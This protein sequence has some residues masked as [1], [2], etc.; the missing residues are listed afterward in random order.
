MI[1][2][3]VIAGPTAS[4]KTDLA[5]RIA[6]ETGA[7]VVNVD[8]VQVY[9]GFDVGTAKPDLP[10]RRGI[11]HHLIDV[12]DPPETI[13]AMEFAKRA[14]HVI[15]KLHQQ[16]T[17]II[18]TAGTGLWL[19]ALLRGL[20]PVPPADGV[21][22]DRLQAALDSDGAAALHERLARVDAESAKNIHPNDTTRVIRCLEVHEQ[23]GTPMSTLRRNHNLGAPRYSAR[24]VVLDEPMPTLTHRIESRLDAMLNSGWVEEVES[25]LDRW[26]SKARG[27]RSVGYKELV[28]HLVDGLAMDATRQAIRK[29][30]RIY[31][32]RQATWFRSEP[33]VTDRLTRDAFLTQASAFAE[34][35]SH[36]PQSRGSGAM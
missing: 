28:S 8:S 30:T 16:G 36:P 18:V 34:Q 19:R 24:F 31:A 7:Q 4:G 27:L 25:L 29:A 26:G 15:H 5:I 11:E 17:P 13:D 9:R 12:L 22:R 21:I 1:P 10:A 14:D 20:V 32:R 3:L 23:T 35:L 2:L 6:C 33:G